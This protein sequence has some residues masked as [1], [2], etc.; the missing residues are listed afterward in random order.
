MK[1]LASILLV[2]IGFSL[3]AQ[4]DGHIVL[5]DD[6]LSTLLS[7]EAIILEDKNHEYLIKDIIE[8]NDSS[9]IYQLNDV[10]KTVKF[11]TSRFWIKFTGHNNTRLDEFYLETARPIT[12]KVILYVIEDSK[13]INTLKNGD[14][15]SYY[16]KAVKHRKNIFPISI[17]QG[18]NRTFIIE[19]TS[20]GEGITLPLIIHDKK[21]F[22]EE[23]YKVQFKNGFYYGLVSLIIVL[24]FFFYLLLRDVT[25]LYY[26]LYVFFQGL[27]QFSLDGYSHHHFFSN[28][29][30]LVNRFPP[31]VG[32][33]AILFMLIY[34]DKFL[35]IKV[36][37]PFFRKA[38]LF[39][40]GL[41]ILSLIMIY[42]PGKLH[43]ISYPM[44]NTASLLSIL[45]SVIAIFYLRAK[46][47]K[48]DNYFT[49]AFVV[50]IAGA[51]IF[52]LGNFNI[53]QNSKISHNSLKISSVIEFVILSIAMSYKYKQLQQDKEEAQLIALQ[54]LQEKNA[55]MD[56]SNIKL[57]AKVKERTAE[58]EL[59]KEEL[60]IINDEVF[61][62]I[63]YAKR[64]QEAIL[65]SA[66]QVKSLL[67][68]SFI[69]YRPKDVVS[70]D[71]YFVVASNSNAEGDTSKAVFAA[72]DCT[73]HGVPGAFMS[74]V[75]NNLLT[76]SIIENNISSPSKALDYLN[77]GVNKT[78]KASKDGD[79]VRDGMDIA[80]CTL[81]YSKNELVFAGAKNPLYIVRKNEALLP[82]DIIK[83]SNEFYSLI[84]FK[85]DKQPIGNHSDAKLEPF[86]NHIIPIFP[87]DI[88]YTFT[89]GFPDQFG[90]EKGK[91]FNYKRFRELLISM[92]DLSMEAQEKKLANTFDDWKGNL[93][94]IDDL[95]IIG[96][97]I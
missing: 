6:K 96:V 70:G 56:E 91:K 95:L 21:I 93:E 16:Q 46:K 61:S 5:T 13:V 86:S 8:L 49:V 78:L 22:F 85:G 40:G 28:N 83:Q 69:F 9:S 67:P 62:S 33:L 68:K 52:I 94:Q 63:K 26:I 39:S 31:S 84:E 45:L 41:T 65:P 89:D 10:N 82:N 51:I 25:F 76:Q 44:V 17:P 35:N 57:A 77:E 29:D 37:A 53:I 59:Q 72:V 12:D 34:I 27:L 7:K 81:D 71:F 64:I 42:M 79:T 60:S 50:L 54:N 43:V 24:F 3:F 36:K 38:F 18:E 74:I 97:K 23:D 30:Y 1:L 66:E 73:G 90:G 11:T 55:L 14:D 20:G 88:I 75:G 48:V 47:V 19:I 58:I 32:C 15:F 92:G 87:N 4:N 80:L 2:L